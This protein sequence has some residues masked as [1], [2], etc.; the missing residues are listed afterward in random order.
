MEFK[1][2]IKDIENINV[3]QNIKE[4]QYNSCTIVFRD[5]NNEPYLFYI[6]K[7]QKTISFEASSSIDCQVGKYFKWGMKKDF[8]L[9]HKIFPAE[10]NSIVKIINLGFKEETKE[11]TKEEIEKELGYKIKI[12]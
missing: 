6:E 5:S 10:D 8:S 7:M 12:I 1:E 4:P 3:F 11:M 2:V 9:I